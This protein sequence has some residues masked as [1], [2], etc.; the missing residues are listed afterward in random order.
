MLQDQYIEFLYTFHVA[1]PYVTILHNKYIY[2][3][4]EIR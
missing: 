1:S 4:Q 3:N 2:K